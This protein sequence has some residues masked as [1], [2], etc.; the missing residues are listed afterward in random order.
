MKRL[1]VL[2]ILAAG[3]NAATDPLISRLGDSATAL[4]SADYEKALKIDE[5][6][7]RDM[8]EQLGPGDAESKWFSVVVTHKALAL[9]GLG[10]TDDAI[11]YW[12]VAQNLYPAIAESD[13]SM[14]GAP[15]ELLKK[16][17]LETPTALRVGGDV[18]A[19]QARKRVEPKYPQGARYFGVDGVAIFESLIDANGDVRSIRI[20]K[21]LPS[22]TLSYCALEALHQWKF[23]P[24]TVDG[25]P[26][27]VLFNLTIN[28]KIRY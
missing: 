5:R 7:I 6:L 28:Y 14:F 21:A 19:P 23:T 24:A 10:R 1:L 3:A 12:Q 20:L 13:M 15:A 4:K 27:E 8:I 11:W 17:P 22:P 25:K 2:L 26:V 9:A 18:R 16:H